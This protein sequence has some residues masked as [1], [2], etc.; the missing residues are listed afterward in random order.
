MRMSFFRKKRIKTMKGVATR[1]LR[2]PRSIGDISSTV[3][4]TAMKDPAHVRLIKTSNREMSV[5]LLFIVRKKC[6]DLE[7]FNN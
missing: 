4:F 3:T 5:L 2:K 7:S 6:I 1:N